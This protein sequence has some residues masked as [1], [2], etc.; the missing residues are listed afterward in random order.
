MFELDENQNPTKRLKRDGGRSTIMTKEGPQA[1][2]EA[3]EFLKNQERIVE[4]QRWSNR[5]LECSKNH[6][7]D[8]GNRGIISHS[9]GRDNLRTKDRL[10]QYGGIVGCYGENISVFCKTAKEVMI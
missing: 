4:K 9:S 1:V 3:I 5:M 7:I 6:A 2:Y 10:K 8:L